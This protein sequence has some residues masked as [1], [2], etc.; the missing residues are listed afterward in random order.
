[1]RSTWLPA[2]DYLDAKPPPVELRDDE[3]AVSAPRPFRAFE[4]LAPQVWTLTTDLGSHSASIQTGGSDAVGLHNYSLAIG[5]DIDHGDTDVGAS[6]AYTG[7]RPSFR[8]S[9]ART[10]VT[11]SGWRVDGVNKTFRE[12]DWSGT[13]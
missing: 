2:R 9:G 3:V 8:L 4:T 11:R 7:W 6:Y 10:L 13:I 5:L 12:E 1:D